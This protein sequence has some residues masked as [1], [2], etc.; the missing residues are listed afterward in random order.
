MMMMMKKNSYLKRIMI[1]YINSFQTF[2][3]P[4]LLYLPLWHNFLTDCNCSGCFFRC[5]TFY[6]YSIIV[7]LVSSVFTN[8]LSEL[9]RFLT[10]SGNVHSAARTYIVV[11]NA[12][13]SS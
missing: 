2:A 13:T 5:H 12:V 3:L 7:A 4:C 8:L 6:F 11:T 1:D 9:H 10:G